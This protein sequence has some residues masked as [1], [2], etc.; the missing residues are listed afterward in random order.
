MNKLTLLGLTQELLLEV[1]G[2]LW[3][4]LGCIATEFLEPS[5][6]PRPKFQYEDLE[7]F[8]STCKTLYHLIRP[9]WHRVYDIASIEDIDRLLTGQKAGWGPQI[10]W[11]SRYPRNWR[12]AT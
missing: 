1:A 5:A 7:A 11:V 2:H 4:P 10:Q 12:T 9:I 8:G 6:F 3:D